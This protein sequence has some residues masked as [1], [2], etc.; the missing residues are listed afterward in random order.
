ML[1]AREGI[2][3]KKELTDFFKK[4]KDQKWFL[5][6]KIFQNILVV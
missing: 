3:G 6:L 4:K 5:N 1:F 2:M